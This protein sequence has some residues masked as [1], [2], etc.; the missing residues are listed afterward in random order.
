MAIMRDTNPSSSRR[1]DDPENRGR[2][3][4]A[5]ADTTGDADADPIAPVD[6]AASS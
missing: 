5:I 6:D 1:W 4:D 2:Y 3:S